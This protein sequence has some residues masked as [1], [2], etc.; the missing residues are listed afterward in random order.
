[1]SLYNTLKNKKSARNREDI[2]QMEQTLENVQY[3]HLL[4]LKNSGGKQADLTGMN[5]DYYSNE[6]FAL[7]D[8]ILDEV[9]FCNSQLKNSEFVQ[10]KLTKA[11][12]KNSDL[13][14]ADFSHANLV[15]ANFSNSNLN[16]ANLTYS[17][18]GGAVLSGADLRGADLRGANLFNTIFHNADITGAKLSLE[19]ISIEQL[20]QCLYTPELAQMIKAKYYLLKAENLPQFATL[21][22]GLRV[23]VKK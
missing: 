6:G 16:N 21:K 2:E 9:S 3:D 23:K 1:M 8:A 10:A 20:E 19:D 13:T 18:L 17:E 22:S 7:P 4:W 14:N 11:K 5:Y 15:F 12:F